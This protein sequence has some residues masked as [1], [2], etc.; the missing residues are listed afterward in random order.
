[1]AN[2]LILGQNVL[3]ALI[4]LLAFSGFVPASLLDEGGIVPEFVAKYGRSII[5]I[6]FKL[7][8]FDS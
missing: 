8:H 4:I 2:G 3:L 7:L 5:A 1:M 6:S